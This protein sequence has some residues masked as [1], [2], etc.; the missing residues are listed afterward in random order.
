MQTVCLLWLE[1]AV[2]IH[3]ATTN[4]RVCR[5]SLYREY[6]I[7]GGLWLVYEYSCVSYLL[8]F[9]LNDL[10]MFVCYEYQCSPKDCVLCAWFLITHILRNCLI[11]FA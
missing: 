5:N 2:M 3:Y 11:Q 7:V 4:L 1:I 6:G 9:T 8:L 10:T